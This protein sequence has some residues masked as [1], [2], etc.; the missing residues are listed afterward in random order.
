MVH[1]LTGPDHLSAL[2]TLSAVSDCWTS[3][4]MGVRWGLGH[5]TGLLLVGVVLILRDYSQHSNGDDGSDD[6]DEDVIDMPDSVS[7]FFESLVG[8]FMLFLGIYGFRR[9]LR[10]RHEY[11]GRIPLSSEIEDVDDDDDEDGVTPVEIIE[12]RT[13]YHDDPHHRHEATL[14]TLVDMVV[15]DTPSRQQSTSVDAERHGHTMMNAIELSGSTRRD[16]RGWCG[17]ELFDA[18]RRF[19]A[20]SMAVLAGVIHG[21][22]GPGGVL[23][24]IPA[25]QLHDWKLA[26]I[27]LGCFC[28]SST[29]TMGCFACF[30]GLFS[31]TVGRRTH[32]EF[33]IHCFSSSLSI[34]VGI[35]WLVLLSLGKLEDVFP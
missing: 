20:K 26:T 6:N 24:V 4:F 5:S 35:T 33:H 16:R 8:F 21:L 32:L 15:S 23:G 2:A 30:Y 10:L 14:D 12:K 1:V 19:S 18:S 27:Y 9:A 29:I 31:S 11:Q 25:V 34:L 17:M 22:A 7:H 28:I 13:H 3:F